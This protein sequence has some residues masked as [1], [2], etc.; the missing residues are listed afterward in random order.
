MAV[1]RKREGR[2]GAIHEAD[3][4]ARRLYLFPSA[5]PRAPTQHRRLNYGARGASR[6]DARTALI[7]SSRIEK[8]NRAASRRAYR[9]APYRS[10]FTSGVV[11]RS[12]PLISITVARD[13]SAEKC[14]SLKIRKADTKIDFNRVA[15]E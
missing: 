13:F 1:G 6:R 14:I 7:A 12:S 2:G 8:G 3:V 15:R 10:L 11:F 5:F 9:R 4:A